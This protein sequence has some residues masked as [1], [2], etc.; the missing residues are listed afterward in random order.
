MQVQNLFPAPPRFIRIPLL[1]LLLRTLSHRANSTSCFQAIPNSLPKTPGGGGIPSPRGR[2]REPR[3]RLK[4]S[5]CRIHY[6]SRGSA[7]DVLLEPAVH[8]ARL[9][10]GH[11]SVVS[12]YVYLRGRVRWVSSLVVGSSLDRASP[13]FVPTS[14]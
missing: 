5:V 14:N 7:S 11:S 8:S 6:L 13:F 10:S 2:E 3:T 1:F 9:F 4:K 12:E